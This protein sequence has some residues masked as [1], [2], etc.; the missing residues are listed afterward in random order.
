MCYE[1]GHFSNVPHDANMVKEWIGME[2]L[3]TVLDW[4]KK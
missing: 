2:S 4:G 3:T 1:S